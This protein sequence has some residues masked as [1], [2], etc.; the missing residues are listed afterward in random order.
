MLSIYRR[1]IKTC[2]HRSEGRKYRR[3]RC[4]IWADGLIGGQEIRESLRTRNWEE[5]E[6]EKLPKL[7]T[8]FSPST[9]AKAPDPI[10]IAQAWEEFLAD[11]RARNL[12]EPTL[13]KYDLLSRQMSRF[14]EDRGLR[15]LTEFDL[16]MLRKFRASWPN[17]NLG[18]LK[19]LD[20]LRA[21]FRFVH[22]S[23]WLD[24]NPARK[25]ESPKVNPR[26]TM[27][28]T[29]DQVADILIACAQYGNTCRGGKYRG[30]ENARRIRAFV[31]LLRHSGLRIGDAVTLGRSR[32][33]G[34]KLFLYTAKT[35]TPV[36]CPLPDFVL[37]A[38]EA[39]PKI[40]ETYFFWTG[41]SDIQSATGDWQRTLK[42]VF[43]LAGIPDGHAHRFR[44]TFAVELLQAH[45]PMDRV[46]VLLGHSSIKVT[47]KH[48]SP[49]VRARQEQLEAD[50]RRAWGAIPL[51]SGQTKGTLGVHEKA[52]RVN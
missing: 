37:N 2:A 10:T 30:P 46:S 29:P 18:A 8:K 16:P 28:Y 26:P 44:D 14:A 24:E 32:I 23:K 40:S 43:R 34:D 17:Q 49:W 1:H 25:L 35:G 50:V 41:E 4:P 3:C 52:E 51:L 38:L 45:V 20:Y 11:A 36:Y 7:K 39:M 42:A 27:P 22:E 21:F 6:E 31:L 13:Y 12:R 48:Y 5:A 15:F 47:E 33:T 9:E 19:K